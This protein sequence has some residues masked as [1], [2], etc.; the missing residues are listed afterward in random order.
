MPGTVLRAVLTEVNSGF[1]LQAQGRVS[2]V[3]AYPC[4]SS[5]IGWS[6]LSRYQGT[7]GQ[8]PGQRQHLRGHQMDLCWSRDIGP[9]VGLPFA[10]AEC[11]GSWGQ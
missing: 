5:H 7:K 4:S 10:E 1:R 9:H 6:A 8:N 3:M 11:V 2:R